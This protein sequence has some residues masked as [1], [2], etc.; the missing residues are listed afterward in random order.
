MKKDGQEVSISLP[1]LQSAHHVLSGTVKL[2]RV[3]GIIVS[4]CTTHTAGHCKTHTVWVGTLSVF[5]GAHHIL[6]GT[7]KLTYCV[8]VCVWE[9][10]HYL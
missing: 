3:C 10:C 1:K 9:H 5:V 4:I 2:T 8:C 7:V 6:W